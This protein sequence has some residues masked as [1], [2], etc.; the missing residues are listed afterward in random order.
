MF[1]EIQSIVP[2]FGF[3]GVV[4]KMKTVCV[5]R[6]HQ[7]ARERRKRIADDIDVFKDVSV[8]RFAV[9]IGGQRDD[10]A[11]FTNDALLKRITADLQRVD[12][13]PFLP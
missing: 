12:A 8:G 4:F 1:A 5:G 6:I 13:G 3:D 2:A 9:Q 11:V 10:L 7:P